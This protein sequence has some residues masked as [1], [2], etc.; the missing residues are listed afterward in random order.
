VAKFLIISSLQ[1]AN[2]SGW[3]VLIG[4]EPN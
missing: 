4:I 1:Q 2:L 3:A